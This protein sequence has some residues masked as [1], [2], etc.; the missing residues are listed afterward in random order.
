MDLVYKPTVYNVKTHKSFESVNMHILLRLESC[1][2][3]VNV[4]KAFLMLI[5]SDE[6]QP[7]VNHFS[8]LHLQSGFPKA[9]EVSHLIF[10]L[11]SILQSCIYS[12]KTKLMN[13]PL[14]NG[15]T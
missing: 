12:L 11:N 2:S 14:P 15:F 9:T 1:C 13:W 10:E 8:L 5:T 4:T 7:N 3:N 6:I